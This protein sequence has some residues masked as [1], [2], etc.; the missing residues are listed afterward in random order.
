M[1]RMTAYLRTGC[2]EMAT[3]GMRLVHKGTVT[4][5]GQ[6][7]G[8]PVDTGEARSGGRVGLNTPP[9]FAPPP[10][11]PAYPIMGDNE[12]DNV[13]ASAQLGDDF[14]WVNLVPYSALLE[15]KAEGAADPSPRSQRATDGFLNLS[16]AQ[17]K[18][19]VESTRYEG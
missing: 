10:E 9:V 16:I 6:S 2:V 8:T 13:F 19:D 17:A 4:R 7:P 12:I 11:A 5:Y 15:G 18:Q 1:L 14:L 3:L